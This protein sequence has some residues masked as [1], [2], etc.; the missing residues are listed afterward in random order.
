MAFP[1][2]AGV[3]L[4]PTSL[5]G[6]HGVGD[7]G[8]TAKQF[9]DFLNNAALGIWQ[10]LPLGPTGGANSPYQAMSSYAGNPL[11]VSLDNLIDLELLDRADLRDAPGNSM[12]AEFDAARAFKEKT[13]RK[14]LDRFQ[15]AR[16]NAGL[17]KEFEEFRREHR[18]WL[19]DFALFM[20]AKDF[21]KGLPWY[22]WP[23]AALRAHTPEGV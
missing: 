23:D 15:D 19:D 4:H 18:D 21:Y 14:A 16:A 9:V 5:P 13:L 22:A 2:L 12:H 6:G 17:A 8:R 10:V 20:A 3:I 1:R 7:L 11:L